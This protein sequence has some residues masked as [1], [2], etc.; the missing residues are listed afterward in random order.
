MGLNIIPDSTTA[1][2]AFLD[3]GKVGVNGT[4]G[5]SSLPAIVSR[6]APHLAN[7]GWFLDDEP[8]QQGVNWYLLSPPLLVKEAEKV[9]QNT[10]LPTLVD[11]QHAAYTTVDP[12]YNG[13]ADIW[14]A[15]PYG[16][17]V[18]HVTEAISTLEAIQQR[19]I[20]LFQNDTT[21]TLIVPK[22]YLAI[23]DGA[24][25]ILYFNWDKL[26]LDP[27]GYAEVQRVFAELGSL[28]EVIFAPRVSVHPPLGI[29]A[30]GRS[31]QG[32]TYVLAVNPN[33][34]D[35]TGRFTAPGLK[36]GQKIKVEF[37]NRTITSTAGG[38]TDTFTGVSRH[39]YVY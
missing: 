11:F 19:P 33:A 36:A 21:S 39:V 38:F 2:R 22:A 6:Y 28:K 4:G 17:K 15:E 12:R 8:D 37:E 25:G 1:A 18:E 13:S 29:S 26:S 10:T 35:V 9:R 14:M 16:T 32:Q 31:Y 23:I 5:I 3:N 34:V 30:A 24:T 20:W 7:I 27:A